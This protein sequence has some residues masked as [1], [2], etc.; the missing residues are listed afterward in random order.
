MVGQM[1][2]KVPAILR[3]ISAEQIH[4]ETE[5]HTTHTHMNTIYRAVYIAN[6][7]VIEFTVVYGVYTSVFLH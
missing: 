2:F 6:S 1:F 7:S 3:R 4:R 5:A